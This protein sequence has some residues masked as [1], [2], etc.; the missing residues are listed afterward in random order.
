MSSAHSCSGVSSPLLAPLSTGSETSYR[1]SQCPAKS[2]SDRRTRASNEV[3]PFPP[4]EV[5]TRG[6]V[7]WRGRR[8]PGLDGNLTCPVTW[9]PMASFPSGP[10]PSRR[11]ALLLE[12][13]NCGHLYNRTRCRV[14]SALSLEHRD[15][16]AFQTHVSMYLVLNKCSKASSLPFL[17]AQSP[18]EMTSGLLE[19]WLED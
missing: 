11:P 16:L 2:H 15:V 13:M 1:L 8:H 7:A 10:E 17:D 6:P 14:I 18:R 19:R 12:R 5:G 4:Q 9:C 3:R